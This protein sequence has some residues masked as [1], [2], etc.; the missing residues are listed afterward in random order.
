V[1]IESPA[2][3]EGLK[4]VGRIVAEALA[5]LRRLV[6]PGIPTKEL[7]EAGAAFLASRN[8][9]SAPIVTYQFP[10]ATCIS[11]NEVAAH[12]IP[13]ELVVKAG[14]LVKLDVSAECDGFFADA[15]TTVAV[16]PV[17]ADRTELVKLAR[18][19]LDAGITAARVGA[20]INRIGQAID[21]VLTPKGCRAIADLPG[22][23]VG[24]R[25]HEEPSI[26]QTFDRRATKALTEGLVITIEPHVT[27]GAGRIR[28]APDGWT[29][30]TRDAKAVALF[31]HT[32][33]VRHDGPLIVT[34]A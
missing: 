28:E 16:P 4:H 32:I 31:E 29:L 33:V 24:R 2:D 34:A 1:S 15:A 3:L 27:R 10:G 11:V 13:G 18:R 12:G 5:L 19:A 7:D 23:G 8:A 6:R 22:H 21:D 20:P 17:T 30:S 26:P 25:L 9:R 14:D